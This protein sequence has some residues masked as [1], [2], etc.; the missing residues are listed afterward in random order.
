MFE[1]M[2]YEECRELTDFLRFARRNS[3]LGLPRELKDKL[4]DELNGRVYK[5][6][7]KAV[8]TGEYV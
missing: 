4:L 5:I 3:G 2:T 8:E 7:P 1:G 6:N